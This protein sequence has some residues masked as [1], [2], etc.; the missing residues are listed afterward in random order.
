[1]EE[2][3]KQEGELK[4]AGESWKNDQHT[5]KRL[6]EARSGKRSGRGGFRKKPL[7]RRGLTVAESD[8]GQA[9][10]EAF[11]GNFWS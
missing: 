10:P 8:R 3:Y 2:N 1:M 7:L 9:L 11:P 5:G 4:R 6:K